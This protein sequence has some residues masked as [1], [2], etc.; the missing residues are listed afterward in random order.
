[1]NYG[2]D[3]VSCLIRFYGLSVLSISRRM[4]CWARSHLLELPQLKT[5]CIL[6][7]MASVCSV[8]LLI[9]ETGVIVL[10]HFYADHMGVEF[11]VNG[12]CLMGGFT[13]VLLAD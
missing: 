10:C 13:L 5:Q 8:S 1:M 11:S 2:H 6:G 3:S 7:K 4:A 12:S 9:C